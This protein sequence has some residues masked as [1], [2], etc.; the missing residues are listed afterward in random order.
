MSPDLRRAAAFETSLESSSSS[1]GQWGKARG[2]WLAS[3]RPGH[4]PAPLC[5]PGVSSPASCGER[6]S[7]AAAGM[8]SAPACPQSDAPSWTGC[9]CPQRW[10]GSHADRHWSGT[11][12]SSAGCFL[13]TERRNSAPPHCWA[14]RLGQRCVCLP[15]ICP[16]N[17]GHQR[18][19]LNLRKTVHKVKS[20]N[21][22]KQQ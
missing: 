17:M 15:R 9:M 18:C 2:S 12:W 20:S 4:G 13:C 3:G 8:C 5:I 11:R 22:K 14:H 16:G 10:R 6:A 1:S 21:F 7:A 19:P